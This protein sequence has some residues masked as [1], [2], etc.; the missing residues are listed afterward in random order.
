MGWQIVS[1][2]LVFTGEGSPHWITPLNLVT[3]AE[4]SIEFAGLVPLSPQTGSKS[5]KVLKRFWAPCAGQKSLSPGLILACTRL[6]W[7]HVTMDLL[8]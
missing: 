4:P 3:G 6:A 8:Q 2:C 7:L 5:F 1:L